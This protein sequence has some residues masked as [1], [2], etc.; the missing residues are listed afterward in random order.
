MPEFKKVTLQ[1]RLKAEL[2]STLDRYPHAF[3][4]FL[5][6]GASENWRILHEIQSQLKITNYVI[7]ND[8]Y[9]AAE[10]LVTGL[11]AGRMVPAS[12]PLWTE[13]LKTAG[14]INACITELGRLLVT[15]RVKSS[16]TA[17]KAVTSEITYLNNQRTR[18]DR[19]K[20][21]QNGIPIGSG[22]QETACKTYVVQRHK[23]SGMMWRNRGGQG[24]MTLRALLLSNGLDY[25]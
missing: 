6:N 25:A 19:A 8:F 9:H 21:I 22:I 5:A 17:L 23:A 16:P 15:Q 3:V 13:R 18:M 1:V 7:V 10:H 2:S 20:Y 4:V 11:K 14:G 24:I 12:I